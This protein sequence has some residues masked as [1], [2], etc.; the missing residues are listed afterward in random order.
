MTGA[1]TLQMEEMPMM[2]MVMDDN[3]QMMAEDDNNNN[4]SID[5][6]LDFNA[7]EIQ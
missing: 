4:N 6:N 7:Q 2:M 3:S 5:E 1:Q